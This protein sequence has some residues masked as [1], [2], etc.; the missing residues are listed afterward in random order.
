MCN[1]YCFSTAT[2]VSRT[3]LT[4]TFILQYIA[5][6]VSF[7]LTSLYEGT[8]RIRIKYVGYSH[9]V[10]RCRHFIIFDLRTVFYMAYNR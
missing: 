5:C 2:M 10:P 7:V 8:V 1:T 9:S 6:L 3:L 4:V